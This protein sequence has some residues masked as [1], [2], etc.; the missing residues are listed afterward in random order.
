MLNDVG[1]E[2]FGLSAAD[3][4]GRLLEY[5]HRVVDAQPL[6]T[7]FYAASKKLPLPFTDFMFDMALCPGIVD[8]HVILELA[9]VAKEV[10]LFPV[11]DDSGVLSPLVGSVLLGLQQNHYGVEVRDVT[12][13]VTGKK[14]AMLRVWAKLCHV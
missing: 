12:T 1:I 5:G 2:V 3:L 14:N 6:S 8:L 13:P 11:I 4:Q 9:R 7:T 10:R